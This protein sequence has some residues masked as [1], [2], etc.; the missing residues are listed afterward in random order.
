MGKPQRDISPKEVYGWQGAHERC[1]TS[2]AI[3]EM[4]I[5]PGISHHHTRFRAAKINSDSTKC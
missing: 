4:Q 5:K 2:P 1:L 3:R